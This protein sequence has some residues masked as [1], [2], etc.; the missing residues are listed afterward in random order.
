MTNE[1]GLQSLSVLSCLHFEAVVC[2]L[3]F[4]PP[5]KLSTAVNSDSNVATVIHSCYVQSLS[6]SL[7]NILSQNIP[8]YVIHVSVC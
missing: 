3:F 4:M 7:V 6:Q 2:H 8:K 1:K 5:C